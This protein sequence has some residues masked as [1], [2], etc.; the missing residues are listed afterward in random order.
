M[1]K[2]SKSE[3]LKEY[4]S[5]EP[6]VKLLVKRVYVLAFNVYAW[7]W[8]YGEVFVLKSTN[9]ENYLLWFFTTT[10]MYFFVLENQVL[11]SKPKK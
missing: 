3:F 5:A 8:L 2:A 10:G 11:F 6:K 4:H 1:K 7:Y 9:I